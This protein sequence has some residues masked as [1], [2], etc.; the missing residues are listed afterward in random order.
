MKNSRKTRF[1]ELSIRVLVMTALAT[2]VAGAN[3]AMAGPLDHLTAAERQA[4]VR[5]QQLIR[6]RQLNAGTAAGAFQVATNAGE[7]WV[8]HYFALEAMIALLAATDDPNSPDVRA[9]EKYLK[10]YAND[11]RQRAEG[12]AHNLKGPKLAPVTVVLKTCRDK[13][14]DQRSDAPKDFDSIDSYAGLYL[15]AT[16][17][18]YALTGK[19]PAE[20]RSGA[21][22]SLKALYN[23]IRRKP[24][25]VAA[26]GCNHTFPNGALNNGLPIARASYPMHQLMDVVEVYAGLKE[27]APMFARLGLA[28]EAKIAADLA[29]GVVRGAA[30]FKPAAKTG[31]YP[32]GLDNG[33]NPYNQG[34]LYPGGLAQLFALAYL[35]S[36]GAKNDVAL[37]TSL[38]K[39]PQGNPAAATNTQAPPERWL[40]AASRVAPQ[41]APR[42]RARVVAE[43]RTFNAATYIDRPAICILALIGKEAGFPMIPA[44]K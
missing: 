33:N 10:F 26:R 11:A 31:H 32:V 43:C 20:I 15:V 25:V 9:V 40:I 17:R 39:F 23:V 24:A 22:L 21:L 19:L 5:C 34:G 6:A 12:V 36:L 29:A 1:F 14:A 3:Q 8:E 37:W 44:A 4:V 7:A 42:W 13:P 16:A 2:I 35:P 27:S 30:L 41:E 28:N 18:Y 38:K